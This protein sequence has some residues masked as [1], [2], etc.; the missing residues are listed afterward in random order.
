MKIVNE[1]PPML[2]RIF[3]AGM[4]PDTGRVVFTYGDTIYNPSGKDVP[5][6]LI[7]HESVHAIQQGDDPEGWWER[8]L[9]DAYFRLEQE[10]EAYAAQFAFICDSVKDRNRR[11][12]VLIDIA[13][14][15]SGPTYGSMI[16]HTAASR[17]IKERSKVKP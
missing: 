10:A 1:K 6:Y 7:A 17:M 13:S 5:S 11:N 12:L 9:H 15:L 2:E 4:K 16:G 8:Y 3:G 14:S